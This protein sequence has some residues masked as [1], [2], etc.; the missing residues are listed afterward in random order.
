M[1]TGYLKENLNKIKVKLYP[2]YALNGNI[3]PKCNSR[4]IQPF[5]LILSFMFILSFITQG[6]AYAQSGGKVVSNTTELKTYLNSQ[7]A[8]K[9][10]EPIKVSMNANN[11]VFQKTIPQTISSSGKYVNLDLSSTPITNIP[12]GAFE[13]C[14]KLAGII[15]PNTVTSIGDNAFKGCVNLTSI[16]IPDSVTSIGSSAFEGCTNLMIV[17]MPKSVTTIGKSAFLGC[18][19]LIGVTIN[20]VAIVEEGVFNRCTSLTSITIPDSVTNI[21]RYAFYGCSSLTSVTFNGT[22]PYTNFDNNAFGEATGFIG[23]L[24]EKYV[25]GG[26]GTYTRVSG[27]TTWTKR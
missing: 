22:I 25:A 23:D 6:N 17:T 15:I 16:I 14:E 1:A 20:G 9:P 19:S 8:N 27:T 18:T 2:K 26:K 11:F 7:A 21:R 5:L 4:K 3:L 10:Y 12:S 13:K 24:R